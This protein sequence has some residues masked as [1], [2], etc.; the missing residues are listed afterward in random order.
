LECGGSDGF[1]GISANP[2]LGYVSD[3]LVTMGGSVILAEFP[4]LC[5]VEQELSDRCADEETANRFMQLMTTYNA[6]AEADGSG[7]YAN[8]IA[9]QYQGWADYRCH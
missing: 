8:P 3:M 7:F 6:R 4:E 1:S 9:G 5:G 2:A